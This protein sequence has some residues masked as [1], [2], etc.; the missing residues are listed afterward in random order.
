MNKKPEMFFCLFGNPVSHSLSPIMH[1]AAFCA[2]NVKA[3]YHAFSIKSIEGA[4]EGMR[5]MGI[6]GASVTIPFKEAVIPYLDEVDEEALS[7]GA[8]NTILNRN[9]YLVGFNTDGIG[10]LR[11]L[12]EKTEPKG[13]KC[14][15]IGAGGAARAIIFSLKK[16]GAEPIILNRTVEKGEKLA[17]KLSCTFLPLKHIRELEAGI[18]INTTPVGM[19]PQVEDSPVPGEYL[20]RFEL[21]VD[22]IYNPRETKLLR[23]ARKKGRETLNGVSMFVY[24]GAEQIRLWMGLHPPIEV[25]RRA[26]EEA[27]SDET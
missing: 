25:M 17:R 18:L 26:V 20:D 24:Q 5:A 7:I 10:F 6:D 14:V 1:R 27:L 16:A 22:I 12:R 2:M 21:V 11:G 23:T 19:Y 3:Y 9:G 4:I 8:V 13:K 15:V